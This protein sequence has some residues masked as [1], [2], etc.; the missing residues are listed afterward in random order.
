M[1]VDKESAACSQEEAV[2]QLLGLD[3][4][5]SIEDVL[6]SALLDL[7]AELAS[8]PANGY[9]DWS[10]RATVWSATLRRLFLQGNNAAGVLTSSS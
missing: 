8:T 3:D 7:L 10:R 4:I 5:S 6:R 1:P 9:V 2:L